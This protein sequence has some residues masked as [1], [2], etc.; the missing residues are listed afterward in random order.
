MHRSHTPKAV[1]LKVIPLNLLP[2]MLLLIYTTELSAKLYVHR[3]DFWFEMW[4][5]LDFFIV[6]TLCARV[7]PGQTIV[8]DF[9]RLG[10]YSFRR[11]ESKGLL[12][13]RDFTAFDAH[14]VKRAAC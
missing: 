9:A 12:R 5:V 3:C 14:D 2:D 13:D 4:N 6:A 7:S 8:C 11:W 1:P 10:C